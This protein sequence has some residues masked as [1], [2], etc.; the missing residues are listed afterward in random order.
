MTNKTKYIVSKA[1]SNPIKLSKD[2]RLVVANEIQHT[3]K[4]VD[5]DFRE[6]TGQNLFGKNAKALK[7]FS[8]Y[9]GSTHHLFNFQI[10][11]HEL[12]AHK[13]TLGDIDV[14]VDRNLLPELNK[15]LQAGQKYG[16]YTVVATKLSGGELHTTMEHDKSGEKH[17]FDFEGAEYVNDEPHEFDKFSHSSDWEDLKHGIKGSHHKSLIGAIGLDTHKFSNL[18]GLGSREDPKAPNWTNDTKAITH[19]LFGKDADEKHLHSFTG[20]VHLIKR[21]IPKEKH[22][23]IVDKF[24]SGTAKMNQNSD[25]AIAYIRKGLGI[26]TPG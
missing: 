3:L 22:A 23:T 14:K 10:S 5:R 12:A 19:T 17:Q 2:N 18:Y 6:K 1:N 25:A 13:P 24:T 9:S 20:L 26:D 7:S 15:F 11:S 16:P 8:A 21:H 4:A